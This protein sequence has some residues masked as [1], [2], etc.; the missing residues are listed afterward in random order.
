[1]A[2]MDTTLIARTLHAVLQTLVE[3]ERL[4]LRPGVLVEDLVLELQGAL[5]VQPAFAQLGSFL[6]AVLIDSPRVEELF[7]DDQ[8]ILA[9]F[10]EVG[11]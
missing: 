2:G 3:R 9:L 1:M 4:V 11:S 6:S 7:A 5:K 10:T 8:E